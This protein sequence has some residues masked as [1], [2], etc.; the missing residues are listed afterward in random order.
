MARGG[1]LTEEMIRPEVADTAVRQIA[2][3]RERVS[4]GIAKAVE[5]PRTG[6]ALVETLP[7]TP[8]APELRAPLEAP[9]GGPV[10]ADAVPARPTGDLPREPT[11][12]GRSSL[13][14]EMAKL[15]GGDFHAT[16]QLQHLPDAVQTAA[17]NAYSK[18]APITGAVCELRSLKGTNV[19]LC[20]IRDDQLYASSSSSSSSSSPSSPSPPLTFFNTRRREFQSGPAERGGARPIDPGRAHGE[21]MRTWER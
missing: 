4:R 7:R 1:H 10:A 16:Q 6:V 17:S 11:M 13:A 2:E 19:D 20:R 12:P 8:V 15:N 14:T 21:E 9:P 18:A 5:L 3:H